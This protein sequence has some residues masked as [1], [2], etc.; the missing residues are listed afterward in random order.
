MIPPGTYDVIVT[1]SG[2]RSARTSFLVNPPGPPPGG[3]PGGGP[4]PA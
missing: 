3:G 4:P 1:G 2:G